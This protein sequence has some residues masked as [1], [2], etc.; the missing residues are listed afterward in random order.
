MKIAIIIGGV[1]VGLAVLLIVVPKLVYKKMGSDFDARIGKVYKPADIVLSDYKAN[2][3][4]R[5]SK[6]GAQLR[7]N[8]ALILTKDAVHFFQFTPET[9]LKIPLS[10]ITTVST[11]RSHA[12]KATGNELLKIAFTENGTPDSFA[13]YVTDLAVWLEKLKGVGAAKAGDAVP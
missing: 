1:L 13:W 3:L 9:D 2:G 7:G 8:G 6:G 12:G 11:T 10:D 4:G 5:A